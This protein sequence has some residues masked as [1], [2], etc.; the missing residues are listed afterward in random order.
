MTRADTMLETDLQSLNGAI[1]Q[2]DEMAD[3]LTEHKRKMLERMNEEQ[4]P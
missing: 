2:Q 1:F 4:I 3:P